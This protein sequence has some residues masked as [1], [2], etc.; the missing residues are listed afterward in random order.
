[1]GFS[2]KDLKVTKLEI[3]QDDAWKAD[4]EQMFC[5]IY[6]LLMGAI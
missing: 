2:L 3:F 6:Q 1:M 5:P 4:Q